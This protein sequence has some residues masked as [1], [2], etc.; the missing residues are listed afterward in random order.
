MRH[1]R[2]RETRSLEQRIF[3]GSAR[4]NC[5]R[6]TD[7]SRRLPAL[8]KFCIISILDI[9]RRFH[10]RRE[11]L[12]F[13]LRYSREMRRFA[14]SFPKNHAL[15]FRFVTVSVTIVQWTD[16]RELF[17]SNCTLILDHASGINTIAKLALAEFWNPFKMLPRHRR[18]VKS[19]FLIFATLRI[20]SALSAQRAIMWIS[21]TESQPGR[22]ALLTLI[23]QACCSRNLS[24]PKRNMITANRIIVQSYRK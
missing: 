20:C 23:S 12:S 6:Q 24:R 19:T 8:L 13:R 16:F 9:L 3:E 11:I 5:F 18:H 17:T 22:W 1:S 15:S 2:S 21:C 14:A 7:C 4:S 10:E